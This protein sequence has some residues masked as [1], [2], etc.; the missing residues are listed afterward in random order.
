MRT[1][2]A[3]FGLYRG[4]SVS[5]V[6]IDGTKSTGNAALAVDRLTGFYAACGTAVA[7]ANFVILLQPYEWSE[8]MNDDDT[9]TINDRVSMPD[10]HAAD[11][12]IC[13]GPLGAIL[14][15]F[16]FLGTRYRELLGQQ[17]CGYTF[18]VFG[19]AVSGYGCISRLTIRRLDANFK[20]I[21]NLAVLAGI[22]FMHTK[23]F[24]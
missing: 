2:V 6:Y 10:V 18:C 15:D 4:L 21:E 19:A 7:L 3:T 9:K 8:D 5:A 11:A 20:D 24:E 14:R 17:H 23:I 1:R 16:A 22:F 12:W 13:E